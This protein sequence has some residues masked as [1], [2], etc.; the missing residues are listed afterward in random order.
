MELKENEVYI[1]KDGKIKQV[2][3]PK[4]GF[5]KTTVHWQNGKPVRVETNFTEEIN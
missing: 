5:G 3:K 1:C 4:H 2:E